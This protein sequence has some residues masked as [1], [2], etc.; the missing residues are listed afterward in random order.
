M[1]IARIVPRLLADVVAVAVLALR[2]QRPLEAEHLELRRQLGLL[3]GAW[4][5]GATG[6]CRDSGEPGLVVAVMRVVLLPDARSPGNGSTL[7]LSRWRL[8][9]RSKSRPG[10]PPIPLQLRR[11][12]QR[13]AVEKPLRAGRAASTAPI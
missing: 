4:R 10:R 11:L 13:L 1:A 5:E 12:I 2:C 3:R 9:W 6:R 8:L 7:A